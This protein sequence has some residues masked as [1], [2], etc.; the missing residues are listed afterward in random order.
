MPRL[1]VAFYDEEVP[2]PPDWSTGPCAYLQLSDAYADE[3]DVAADAGWPRSIVN[4][5]H[6]SISTDPVTVLD[7]IEELVNQARR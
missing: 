1:P 7:A 6:L 2:V 4:G 3:Y 5:A